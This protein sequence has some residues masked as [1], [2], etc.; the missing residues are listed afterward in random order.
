MYH[1]DNTLYDRHINENIIYYIS[2]CSTHNNM[3]RKMY[4]YSSHYRINY[5]SIVKCNIT[6]I[7]RGG[8]TKKY[9][10]SIIT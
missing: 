8:F 4:A 9:N 10:I 6:F 1:Y 3:M 7:K 2:Y 5:D